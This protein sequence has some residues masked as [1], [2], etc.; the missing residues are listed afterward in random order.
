MTGDIIALKISKFYYG[1]LHKNV[2]EKFQSVA[3]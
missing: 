3:S 2:N 1:N